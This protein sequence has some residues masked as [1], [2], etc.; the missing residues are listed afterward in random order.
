MSEN[1]KV[2]SNREIQIIW[3][4]SKCM[5]SGNCIRALP[6]VF[7]P[8]TRPWI[9]IEN[10]DTPHLVEAVGKC[11]SGALSYTKVTETG[12]T[13]GAGSNP[14]RISVSVDGPLLVKG[15]FEYKDAEGNTEMKKNAAFCRC[16]ASSNKP[17]CDGSH[18]KTGF[19]G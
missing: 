9:S 7:N 16:G 10:A 15:E 8:R 1:R 6:G 19:K 5:H 12:E 14:A 17:F 3:Q 13:T 4:A 18:R 11:P 2:Y